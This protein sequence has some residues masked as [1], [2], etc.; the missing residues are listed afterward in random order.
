MIKING[1]G[2]VKAIELLASIELGK[3]IFLSSDEEF[4]KQVSEIAKN[5]FGEEVFNYSDKKL[6]CDRPFS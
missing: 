3:R 1:I 4:R 5:E 2:A 6:F